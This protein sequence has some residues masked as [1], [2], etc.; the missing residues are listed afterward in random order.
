MCAELLFAGC[1][2]TNAAHSMFY[3]NLKGKWHEH[4]S[5]NDGVREMMSYMRVGWKRFGKELGRMRPQ[6]KLSGG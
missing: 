4:P 6:D 3:I 1:A 5:S 2:T